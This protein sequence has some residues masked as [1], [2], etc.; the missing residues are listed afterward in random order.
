MIGNDGRRI[1]KIL[2]VEGL[3]LTRLIIAHT[4]GFFV[5]HDLKTLVLN[6]A[7]WQLSLDYAKTLL[8]QGVNLSIDCFGHY[9]NAELRGVILE[10]DWQRLAGLVALIQKGYSGQLVLGTDTFFKV[11]TRRYGGEGYCRLTKFVIPTLTKL[12]I[13]D[14]DLR[15]ITRVNPAR[16]LAA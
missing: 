7:S 15:Q 6:P 14:Y 12:G 4:D 13:S 9:W 1:A 10:T 3:D 8:D 2:R 11:L 16:L 5:E